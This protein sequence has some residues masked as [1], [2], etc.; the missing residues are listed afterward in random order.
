MKLEPGRMSVTDVYKLMIR[1]IVPR[2]IAWISTVS[3]DGVRNIAP[4]SFFTGITA[5][6]PTVCFAPARKSG[7]T[8]KDTLAN[9]EATG[10]FV[11]NVVTE[12][13]SEAM[14]DTATDYPPDFDEFERAGLTPVQSDLVAPPRIGESP[15]QMECKL[16]NSVEVGND[17]GTLVIGEVVLFHVDE[18][19][20]TDGNV[21]PELLKAVGRMGGQEYT[22]TAD[23]FV[24]ERKKFGRDV[25]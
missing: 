23:R 22:R 4:F 21:D 19:V 13:L 10:E 24:L 25:T 6:P 18:R 7:G 9:V 11:I 1:T 5:N 17:G 15:V 8:K 12:E 14:N 3:S 16:R 20:M 2:P